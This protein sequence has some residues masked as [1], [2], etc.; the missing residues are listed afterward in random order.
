MKI[1]II[2]MSVLLLVLAYTASKYY[3]A[4]TILAA[5]LVEN[6]YAPPKEKDIGRLLKW[7]VQKKFKK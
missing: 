1:A 7:A 6:N 2:I 5:W 4:A 3:F